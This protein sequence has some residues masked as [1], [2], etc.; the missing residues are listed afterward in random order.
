MAPNGG[1]GGIFNK[2]FTNCLEKPY[3]RREQRAQPKGC[4]ACKTRCSSVCF[5][6]SK[7]TTTVQLSPKIVFSPSDMATPTNFGTRLL[8]ESNTLAKTVFQ[9]SVQQ[10][11]E[12][13]KLVKKPTYNEKKDKRKILRDMKNTIENDMNKDGPSV[14]QK[15]RLS[16]NMYD[17]IRKTNSQETK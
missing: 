8:A 2:I 16:W 14:V 15:N 12:Q 7:K 1:K 17:S 6:S 10:I 5:P 11:V 9:Q 13:T 4:Q 3:Q